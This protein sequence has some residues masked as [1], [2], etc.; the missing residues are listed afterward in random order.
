MLCYMVLQIN[1]FLSGRLCSWLPFVEYPTE[2]P[3]KDPSTAQLTVVKQKEFLLP[4]SSTRSRSSSFLVCRLHRTQQNCFGCPKHCTC[5]PNTAHV[6]QTLHTC[7][8]LDT[9]VLNTAQLFGTFS[10]TG[11]QNNCIGHG[12][13]VP[14]TTSQI[15]YN[16]P[17]HNKTVSY[18][19]QLSRTQHGSPEHNTTQL[20]WTQHNCP[21]HSTTLLDTAQ[22]SWTQ[23]NC[24]GHSTTVLDTARLSWTQHNCL[25]HSKTVQYTAKLPW[26][27]HNYSEHSKTALDTA[28]LSRARIQR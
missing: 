23:H 13:T 16:S 25:G 26:T 28:Q 21:G 9:T 6:S 20:S 22:L 27:Q 17:G 5:V 12:R 11:T 24:P 15:Q 10:N 4:S 3:T 7:P 8:G 1:A 19:A 2:S 18:T 14:N